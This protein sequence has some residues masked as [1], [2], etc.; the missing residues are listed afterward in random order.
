MIDTLILKQEEG[1]GEISDHL[2][3]LQKQV[4]IL[5]KSIGQMSQELYPATL[6]L[7]GL[8]AALRTLCARSREMQDLRIHLDLPTV[9]RAL[10]PEIARGLYHITHEGLRNVLRHSGTR[11]AWVQLRIEKGRVSL[12]IHDRGQGFE[13]LEDSKQQG[14]GL[15][16]IEERVRLI[17]GTLHIHSNPGSGSVL[18]VSTALGEKAKT[19]E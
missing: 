10:P 1:R 7:L 8:T 13:H 17:D 9:E 2:Q 16:S 4:D 3:G 12:Q 5:V 19:A 15:S 6:D 11:E 14:I 18:K